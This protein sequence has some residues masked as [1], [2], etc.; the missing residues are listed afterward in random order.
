MYWLFYTRK[1]NGFDPDLHLFLSYSFSLDG[2]FLPH[3][4]NPV[5]I[6]VR[7]ARPAGQLFVHNGAIYRP[8]Q[9]FAV[10]YGGSIVLNKITQLTIQD[11]QE[12]AVGELHSPHPTFNKGMHTLSVLNESLVAIDFKRS[13]SRLSS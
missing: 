9:N 12:E 6:D 11:F 13:I 7:S 4:R 8:A 1:D 5:K 3:F 10:T 2:P